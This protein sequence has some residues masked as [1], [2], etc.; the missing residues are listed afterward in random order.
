M[1]RE[2]ES[3]EEQDQDQ[4]QNGEDRKH[5]SHTVSNTEKKKKKKNHRDGEQSCFP[6]VWDRLQLW[7]GHLSIH[8]LLARRRKTLGGRSQTSP[9]ARWAA[10][11]TIRLLGAHRG[12]HP[13]AASAPPRKHKH[14]R[15]SHPATVT[16]ALASSPPAV[17]ARYANCV[18][19]YSGR[20]TLGST[21]R[22]SVKQP[23][24]VGARASVSTALPLVSRSVSISVASR[25][26]E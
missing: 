11:R 3:S 4:V 19:K 16:T 21:A 13:P 10:E 8:Q 23:R 25:A 9:R 17:A 26:R 12:P 5:P 7:L 22:R 20:A 24:S 14:L 18:I 2:S 6:A 15:R 1:R